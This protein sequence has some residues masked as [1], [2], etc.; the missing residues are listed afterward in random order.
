MSFLS[1]HKSK[2]NDLD[3]HLKNKDQLRRIANGGNSILFSYPPIEENEYIRKAEELYSNNAIFINIGDLLVTYI[4]SIGWPDF[5]ELYHDFKN[6]PY[7][8][9]KAE[10]SNDDY[11]NLIITEII[12]A[13]SQGK[14]PMIIRSGALYG[15]GIENI[16]IMEHNSI[17]TLSLPLVIFYPSK[18]DED[19]LLFLNFRPA[20]KY[21]C[22]LIK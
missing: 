4:E 18:I 15:T 10:D 17:V 8:L 12:N 20:S 11:F 6:T 2:F 3:Y 14:I 13:D 1:D 5:K 22:T 16:N 9:F 21:R 7:K 19:N